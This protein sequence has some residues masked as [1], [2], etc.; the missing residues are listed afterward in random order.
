MALTTLLS[1]IPKI[2]L[3]MRI[4]SSK[5]CFCVIIFPHA[6]CK[7]IS[8]LPVLIHVPSFNIFQRF[9]KLPRLNLPLLKNLILPVKPGVKE[10]AEKALC[11]LVSRGWLWKDNY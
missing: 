5:S 10:A 7:L 1:L 6:V 8:G 2:G 9:L 4:I 3:K 11:A